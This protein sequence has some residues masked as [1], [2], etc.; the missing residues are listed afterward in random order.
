MIESH[1]KPIRPQR[2]SIENASGIKTK[3]GEFEFDL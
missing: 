1:K 2:T 3:V